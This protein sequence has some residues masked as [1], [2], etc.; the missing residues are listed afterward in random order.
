MLSAALPVE[1]RAE[2]AW[3]QLQAPDP[4][5]VAAGAI[6]LLEVRGRARTSRPRDVVLAI[7]VSESTFYP[8]GADINGDG[9][10]GVLSPFAS[11]RHSRRSR[12]F[13]AWTTDPGDTIARA[14]LALARRLL[15]RLRDEEARVGL[16]TFAGR[17]RLRV[18]VGNAEHALHALDQLRL[19][20]DPSGTNLAAATRAGL[21]AL[22]RAEPT[23]GDRERLIVILSDGVA[24]APAPAV[25]ARHFA[26]RAAKRAAERGVRIH[27]LDLGP[28]TDAD[29]VFAEMA[30]LSD[31][32]FRTATEPQR[33]L[34]LAAP[35]TPVQLVELRIHNRT[36]DLSARAIRLFADG[37]FDGLAPLVPGSNVL[38]VSAR[39]ADGHSIA[40]ERTVHFDPRAPGPRDLLLAE[41]L[42]VRSV[43]TEL[44]ATARAATPLTRS[45]QIQTQ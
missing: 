8:S 19:V 14:E 20:L 11:R 27:A 44:A 22:D 31:G 37:S 9:V 38:E 16:L 2:S 36:A 25:H 35:T 13:A 10:L 28:R 29:V 24:T 17:A 40:L 12:R 1:I 39:T 5:Q 43:E 4:G 30:Q 34:E 6:P 7:D 26:R 41:A 33:L 3:L 18:P 21:H 32:V 42:R 45:L 15:L 23:D